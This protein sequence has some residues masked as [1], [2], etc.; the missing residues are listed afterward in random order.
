M[1]ES[2]GSNQADQA[3]KQLLMMHNSG[4]RR[5]GPAQRLRRGRLGTAR[6]D[7]AARDRAGAGQSVRA[8][9]AVGGRAAPL[10]PHEDWR[11]SLP[12]LISLPRPP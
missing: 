9:F 4:G 10:D 2:D 8:R 7:P 3:I 12:C 11:S 5:G 6:Q 1:D